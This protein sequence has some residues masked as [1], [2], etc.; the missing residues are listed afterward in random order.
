MLYTCLIGLI[1]L[2]KMT[3]KKFLLSELYRILYYFTMKV[4]NVNARINS[5]KKLEILGFKLVFDA[6]NEKYINKKGRVFLDKQ[7]RC[8]MQVTN[9]I[10]NMSGAY[11]IIITDNGKK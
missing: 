10:K 9:K 8:R 6:I 1:Y 7:K 5:L 3:V 11:Y 4:P 2:E